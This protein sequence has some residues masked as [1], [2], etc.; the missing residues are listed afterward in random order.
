MKLALVG[1]LY[2]PYYGGMERYIQT[3]AES[4]PL[5]DTNIQ[6]EVFAGQHK[7]TGYRREELNGVVVHR[8]RTLGFVSSTSITC[9]MGRLIKAY[10]PDL[11]HFI[12]PNPTGELMALR[13]R[14]DAPMLTSYVH[15][16]VRQKLLLP[17]YRILQR[18]FL[19]KMS[20]IVVLAPQIVSS[21][22]VLRGYEDKIRVVPAGIDTSRYAPSPES[23][24]NAVKLKASI[25]GDKPLVLA[26]GRLVYYKGFEY[27]IRTMANVDAVLVLVGR[28]PLKNRL[29]KTAKAAGVVGKLRF[30]DTVDDEELALLYIAA[31]LFA[32]PSVAETE[33]YGLVQLEAHAAG[34]P[35]ISTSLPTGV[36][37]VN[38]HK[39]TGL[40]VPPADASS[41]STA[42][43]QLLRNPEL[44]R[45]YGSAAR[46]RAV[47]EFDLKVTVRLLLDV[48]QE[49]LIHF[50]PLTTETQRH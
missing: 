20:R 4:L 7:A 8:T 34:T 2:P 35:V 44:C 42:I 37:F 11:I 22:Q 41:L 14:F 32:L 9:G 3:L 12:S 26:V 33:A 13:T 24:E 43:N 10:N 18:R 5:A 40:V 16:A 17:F 25:S 19:R 48:Y 15:D 29:R 6:V 45:R 47:E 49:T 1:K 30:K 39:K 23:M 50:E 38:Q 28:G 46:K 27:L 31:D 21:S 36:Q